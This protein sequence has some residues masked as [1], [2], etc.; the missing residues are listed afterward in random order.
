M[1]GN[2]IRFLPPGQDRSGDS[3]HSVTGLTGVLLVGVA[4]LVLASC[5]SVT[6][7][8]TVVTDSGQRWAL[9][10]IRNL[11]TTPLAGERVSNM[12]ETELRRRGV[13]IL[14]IYQDAGSSKESDLASLLDSSIEFEKAREWAR[15]NGYRYALTGTVNE[16]HYKTGTDKEPAVGLNLKLIDL[17]TGL[18]LWQGTGS[19]TGWGYANLARIG[20]KVTRD[21][22][23]KLSIRRQSVAQLS[24]RPGVQSAASLVGSVQ[25]SVEQPP[26]NAPQNDPYGL[27]DIPS[28]N[29]LASPGNVVPATTD[30]EIPEVIEVDQLLLEN[31]DVLPY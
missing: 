5:K 11:S 14:G 19:R 25:N 18:V 23:G 1:L 31:I 26:L 8:P 21:L 10:P 29:S 17:P 7:T 3:R 13:S 9:L 4:L 2:L 20:E 15:T 28:T 12:V 30:T 27:T 16:W 24:V 22:V 6:T